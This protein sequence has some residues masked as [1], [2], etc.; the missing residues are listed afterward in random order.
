MKR[1]FGFFLERPKTLSTEEVMADLDISQAD[2]DT[3]P[4]DDLQG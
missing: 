4:Q 3:V 2:V 1:L